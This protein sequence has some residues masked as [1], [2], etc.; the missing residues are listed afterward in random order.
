M[1]M[2]QSGAMKK[3]KGKPFELLDRVKTY[4][5]DRLFIFGRDGAAVVSP[6]DD[7]VQPILAEFDYELGCINPTAQLVLNDYAR[8]VKVIQDGGVDDT[9]VLPMAEPDVYVAPM[10]PEIMWH[11]HEPFNNNLEFVEYKPTKGLVEKCIV[12]C[13]ATAV[14]QLMAYLGKMGWKMGCT[15][16]PKYTSKA[17]NGYRFYVTAEDARQSFD[18]AN[19]LDIY[20]RKSS[21]SKYV[22]VVSFSEEQAKAAADLCAHVGKAMQTSYSPV[23]S[24]QMPNLI[25]DA[26]EN[27]LHLGHVTIYEQSFSDGNDST[28][29]LDKVKAA[30]ANGIPVVVCG[31]NKGN[32]GA[33]CFLCEGYRPSDDTYYINWGWGKGFN[34]GWFKMSLL[35]YAKKEESYNF[36]FHKTFLILD[37]RP[38]WPMDVNRDGRI[39]MSDVTEIINASNKGGYDPLAD[40]NYDGKSD[41]TDADD[42]IHKILGK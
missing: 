26:M 28:L 19:I 18:F 36:S 3:A 34:N 23:G 10:F 8:E 22:N 42:T 13:P 1:S 37:K 5:K 39:N 11:Q 21:N 6:A 9:V 32:T 41:I 16:V 24:G 33:H 14:S 17:I 38:S 31:W 12:G 29:H 27:K 40:V 20:T 25:A 30:L 7:N 35:S 4:K 2:S 15:A